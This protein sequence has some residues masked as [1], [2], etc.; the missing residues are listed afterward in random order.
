[1]FL[2]SH[3]PILMLGIGHKKDFYQDWNHNV[4]QGINSNFTALHFLYVK[5][6]IK[7]QDKDNVQNHFYISLK[8]TWSDSYPTMAM[9]LSLNLATN[10]GSRGT[11]SIIVQ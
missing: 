4:V 1:M 9:V 5:K 2:Q 8:P 3:Q 10:S 7:V 6:L 11:G